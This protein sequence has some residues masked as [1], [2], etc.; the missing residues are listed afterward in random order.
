M[1][2][3]TTPGTPEAV[4]HTEVQDAQEVP[5]FKPIYLD[6]RELNPKYPVNE[7]DLENRFR[8]HAPQG[9]QPDR[10]LQL[11]GMARDLAMAIL[12]LAPSSRERTLAL[13]RL[14]EASFWANA[15]ISREK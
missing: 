11:R 13:T 12:A 14:E 4:M 6:G 5:G 2:E 8:Y 15:A 3:Q 7:A 1:A 9:D 10:Y